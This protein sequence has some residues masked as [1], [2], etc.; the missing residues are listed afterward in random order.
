MQ[1]ISVLGYHTN[2][3]H[4]VDYLQFNSLILKNFMS[5]RNGIKLFWSSH[6]IF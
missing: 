2:F 3:F 6:A 4:L 5:Y 1:V